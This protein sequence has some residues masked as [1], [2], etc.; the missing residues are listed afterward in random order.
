MLC[1]LQSALT[2]KHSLEPAWGR[3]SD[4]TSSLLGTQQE[5]PGHYWKVI[6]K[7]PGGT[8]KLT[9]FTLTTKA[10]FCKLLHGGSPVELSRFDLHRAE[11]SVV[12][13][14]EVTSSPK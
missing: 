8:V 9:G 11:V 2:E 5:H 10:Q 3:E 1:H 6:K 7:F 13:F 14:L 4:M 12:A